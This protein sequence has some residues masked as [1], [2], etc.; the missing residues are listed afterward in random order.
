MLF[1]KDLKELQLLA[2]PQ[3][4]Q[5]HW[6]LHGRIRL[7]LHAGHFVSEYL[8]PLYWLHAQLWFALTY[9]SRNNTSFTTEAHLP[10]ILSNGR[11]VRSKSLIPSRQ[12]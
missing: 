2:S 3:Q 5:F 6:S 7:R 4:Y 12:L 10:D 11:I 9:R 8:N 1:E